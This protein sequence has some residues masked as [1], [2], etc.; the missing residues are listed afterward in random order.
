MTRVWDGYPPS[1][2]LNGY[3]TLTSS[4]NDYKHEAYWNSL[5]KSWIVEF[6][7]DPV[8]PESMAGF[9]LSLGPFLRVGTRPDD[10]IKKD[11]HRKLVL[12]REILRQKTDELEAAKVKLRAIR[13]IV[14][15]A[16]AAQG[17]VE[18]QDQRALCLKAL[19][20]SL[21]AY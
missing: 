20:S 16:L 12:V 6:T 14:D 5:S 11:L 21:G 19:H 17:F 15:D 8:A 13:G 18:G 3:Y 7:Q 10:L 2:G 9:G 1:L 4:F